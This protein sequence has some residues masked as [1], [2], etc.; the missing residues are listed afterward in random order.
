VPALW[1]VSQP[2]QGDIPADGKPFTLWHDPH[3]A[4]FFD[5]ELRITFDPLNKSFGL[6]SDG[7]IY[8]TRLLLADQRSGTPVSGIRT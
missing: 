4:V 1:A 6:S 8:T 3:H 2:E 7:Q 5:D